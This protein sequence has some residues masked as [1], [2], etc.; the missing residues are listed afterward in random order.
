MKPVLVIDDA[1]MGAVQRLG[2]SEYQTRAYL[3]LVKMGPAKASELSFFAQVP[4][5]K[6]YGV[7]RELERKGLIHV[8]PGKPELYSA[9]SPDET[10]VPLLLNLQSKLKDSEATVH[11]LSLTHEANRY[12]RRDVPHESSGFWEIEGRPNL[13]DKM[14]HVLLD[15]KRSICYATSAAGLIRAY[16]AQADILDRARERDVRVRILAPMSPENRVIAEQLAE[17]VELRTI[18][19]PFGTSFVSVDSE[20]LIVVDS[21]PD[22]LYVDRGL[23]AAIWTINKLLVDLYEQL[24]ERVWNYLPQLEIR[25]SDEVS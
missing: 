21:R 5:T 24:F 12:V 25:A 13:F 22:D 14:S 3:A 18:D 1:Q 20:Q 6:T 17:I 9:V 16:K 2:L 19:R 7:V 8:I 4:R 11:E 23:D 15:A 10:L